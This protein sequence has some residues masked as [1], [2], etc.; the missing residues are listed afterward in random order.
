MPSSRTVG[1]LA[2]C[3]KETCNLASTQIMDSSFRHY[4]FYGLLPHVCPH[5]VQ[6]DLARAVAPI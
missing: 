5:A 3:D 1:T 6:P 4:L 2:E